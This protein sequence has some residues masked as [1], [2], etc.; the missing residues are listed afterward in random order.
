MVLW[1]PGYYWVLL[2]ICTYAVVTAGIPAVCCRLGGLLALPAG[3]ALMELFVRDYLF[4]ITWAVFG[5]ALGDWPVVARA[6]SFAGPELLTYLCVACGVAV[7]VWL[8]PVGRFERL[9]A[10]AQ[11]PVLLAG[12]V[13]AGYFLPTPSPTEGVLRVAV[14]QPDVGAEVVR[15]AAGRDAFLRTLDH[16]ID[17]TLPD[18]PDVIALPETA[19][20][21]FV[22]YDNTLT[23]WV[24][25]TVVRT[26]RPLLFG[27]LD[28]EE[29][30]PGRA[31][32]ASILITPYNTVTTYRKT[33]LVPFGERVPDPW[34]FRKELNVALRNL[35]EIYPGNEATVFQLA[36]GRVFS[37]PLCSEEA[38]PDLAR[39]FAAGG[40]KLL[41]SLVNTARVKDTCQAMQQLRRA[42]LTA[43][44][45]GLPLVRCASGGPSCVVTPDGRIG[46]A[47]LGPDGRPVR[48][49]GAGVLEAPM[50]HAETLYGRCGDGLGTG[51]YLGAT[52]LLTVWT[53]RR[54]LRLR[55]AAASPPLWEST[56]AEQGVA[57]KA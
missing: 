53:Q 48:G 52:G 4:R 21:G 51:L 6:S 14:I 57:V 29:G 54:W 17:Q 24:K 11:G 56:L 13:V 32:N 42:R 44:A 36:D 16:L 2:I 55:R 22:R 50:G 35:I 15:D 28:R 8:R 3:W 19:F 12:V 39:D 34:P 18:R 26:R 9:L 27:T 30:D 7:A 5:Q 31:Y 33:Q 43:V 45:V 20:P 38:A 47:I 37:T 23:A 1:G 41:L 40:S 25:R 46:E 49:E 10:V